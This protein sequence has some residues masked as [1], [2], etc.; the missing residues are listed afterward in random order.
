MNSPIL[1]PDA[2]LARAITMDELPVGTEFIYDRYR[3]YDRNSV[4]VNPKLGAYFRF[5]RIYL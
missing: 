1:A 3:V 4:P 2:D 5:L